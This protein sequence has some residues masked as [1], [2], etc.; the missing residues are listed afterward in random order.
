MPQ[1]KTTIQVPISSPTIGTS[2]GQPVEVCPRWA[3]ERLYLVRGSNSWPE[4][5]GPRSPY[6]SDSLQANSR[7]NGFDSASSISFQNGQQHLKTD[8]SPLRRTMYTALHILLFVAAAGRAATVIHFDEKR[9]NR[10]CAWV[11]G[12]DSFQSSTARE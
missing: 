11:H 10:G 12:L 3:F 2:F 9:L 8:K 7:H 1:I 4:Q 6:T 5:R